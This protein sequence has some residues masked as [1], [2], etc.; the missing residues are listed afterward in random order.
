MVF[1]INH[2]I[3]YL[4]KILFHA[5]VDGHEYACAKQIQK[6][7]VKTNLLFLLFFSFPSL[8]VTVIISDKIPHKLLQIM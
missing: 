4:T 7:N 3:H 8:S 1:N 5:L 6:G 2:R